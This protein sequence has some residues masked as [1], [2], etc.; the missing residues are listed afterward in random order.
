MPLAFSVSLLAWGLT[1]FPNGYKAAGT[2]SQTLDNIKWGADW[3]VEASTAA[4][5]N[6]S[7][8]TSSI[9]YQVGNYSVDADVRSLT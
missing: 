9:I 7:A 6:G 3:L 4:A 2:T 1:E 8:N 5:S